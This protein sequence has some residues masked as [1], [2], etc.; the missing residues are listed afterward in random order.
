M[1][2]AYNPRDPKLMT[3]K[4]ITLSN[5]E[6]NLGRF[7]A[8]VLVLTL[9]FESIATWVRVL[10]A[11]Q[12]QQSW[13][14]WCEEPRAVWSS[15][16]ELLVVGLALMLLSLHLAPLFD[17]LASEDL[18]P[19]PAAPSLT[20]WKLAAHLLTSGGLTA[21]LLTMLVSG[22]APARFGFKLQSLAEQVR[23]GVTGYMLALAPTATLMILTAS[24]RN[25]ENQNSLLTLL[26]SSQD[27]PTV[28]LICLAAVVIAPLYEELL[29]RVI[30][31]G[32]LSTNFRPMVAIPTTAILFAAIHGVIDG[33]ALIPLALIL[34]YVFHRRHS[35]VSVI[36][37]HGL[38][39]ATM[40]TLAILTRK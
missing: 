7:V 8:L 39:N 9:L 23:D 34:G 18:A 20:A 5:T 10:R 13:P 37:I 26:A 40:L 14:S 35:Y 19:P 21:V 29:F 6:I 28:V 36:V 22:E 2:A 3:T 16:V 38:F 32:W 11:R 12:S 30:L 15:F 17:K 33:V 31:Q 24:V 25:P 4:S 27:I 1:L